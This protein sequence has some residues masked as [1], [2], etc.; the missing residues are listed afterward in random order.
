VRRRRRFYEEEKPGFS[1]HT[2]DKG[3]ESQ[4]KAV[5]GR[6]AVQVVQTNYRVDR[7]F[8]YYFLISLIDDKRR[9]LPGYIHRSELYRTR[10]L[11]ERAMICWLVEKVRAEPA[12]A[13]SKERLP[14]Q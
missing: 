6:V 10:K 4:W 14:T 9:V 12:F 3:Y 2:V 7:R 8:P 1:P 13:D 11:C 5:G